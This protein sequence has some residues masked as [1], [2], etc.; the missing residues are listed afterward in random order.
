MAVKEP[1]G[2]LKKAC[3]KGYTAVGMKMKNG[4]KV[5][6]CVPVKEESNEPKDR[7]W[8][9]TKLTKRYKK[10]TPGQCDCDTM[11]EESDQITEDAKRDRVSADLHKQGIGSHWRNP[12]VLVVHDKHK[13]KVQEYMDKITGGWV[14]VVGHSEEP[15]NE[16]AEKQTHLIKVTVSEP[17]LKS[18]EPMLK[19]V[20]VRA[21]SEEEAIKRAKS[22][23]RKAGYKVHDA[24][25][26]ST[27][28]TVKKVGQMDEGA[29]VEYHVVIRHPQEGKRS[30]RISALT[31][32]E[33]KEKAQ[34]DYPDHK[35]DKVRDPLEKHYFRGQDL[36]EGM[37]KAINKKMKNTLS[38]MRGRES[39]G[40][41]EKGLSWQQNKAKAVK[42]GRAMAKEEVEQISEGPQRDATRAKNKL[43]D[44]IAGANYK[45][46]GA[47][48]PDAEPQ[49]KTAQAHNKAI[50]RS[51]RKM[52][53]GT[54]DLTAALAKKIEKKTGGKE[55]AVR[56]K[57]GLLV[58]KK[59]SKAKLEEGRSR[60][61]T[62]PG[63]YA[64]HELDSKIEKRGYD[65]SGL[66]KTTSTVHV[67][68]KALKTHTG[69][70]SSHEAKQHVLAIASKAEREGRKIP[71]MHIKTSSSPG[72]VT[73]YEHSDRG[74]NQRFTTTRETTNEETIRR[75]S[76]P[77]DPVSKIVTRMNPD[78][79]A[80]KVNETRNIIR[81]VI[82]KAVDKQ[83][84]NKANG[85]TATGE[86]MPKIQI[87][88][89]ID[90]G[91]RN[92]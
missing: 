60:F 70:N 72:W 71:D 52:E 10:D 41:P 69:S 86:A 2:D 31:P 56:N 4:R 83:E 62:S 13:K 40:A 29:D 76:P 22:H 24:Y 15:M 23:F 36:D 85:K 32:T 91:A 48:V 49:H 78:R 65:F 39:L 73:K 14:H 5:P 89:T 80:I 54:R 82:K 87:D 57:A 21:T 34:R 59:K 77:K 66:E 42:A 37:T 64:E 68:G 74:P 28:T 16:E 27:I 75:K 63:K 33:A 61:G 6:N 7:E 20:R 25:H 3:W 35:V 17:S 92:V 18:A 47:P 51:L 79:G 26:H 1:T 11:K 81:E 43:R 50:G 84:T 44:A 46:T 9:T 19:G 53:E 55:T 8:G 38:A 67:N 12:Q 58:T 30:V 90:L 45:R 88:P